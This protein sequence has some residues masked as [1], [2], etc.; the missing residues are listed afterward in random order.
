LEDD[1]RLYPAEKRLKFHAD[2]KWDYFDELLLEADILSKD[3][4]GELRVVE[5]RV[6]T[7]L[8]L[9]AFHDIMK[10]QVLL[11]TV[12][13]EHAPY[14]GYLAG[15]MICDHDHALS[16]VMDHF[17]EL[18]PSFCGLAPEEKASVQFTQCKLSFNHGWV[19]QAEAPPGAAFTKFREALMEKAEHKITQR[20][21][22]LY[23]VHWLTD[24]AGA[25]PTP[26]GGCEKFVIKFPLAVLNSF[27]RSFEFVNRI[28]DQNE[29]EVNEEYLKMRW[30]EWTPSLGPLP[31]GDGSISL[32]RLVCMAQANAKPILNGFKELSKQ[33]R[34]VLNLEMSRTGCVDQSY[35][36]AVCPQTVRD[37]PCGPAFLVYYGLVFLQ[38]LGTDPPY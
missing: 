33:D 35:S 28:A 19:V 16:Y 7:L 18:L 22:A 3:E 32:M 24:L 20:D 36:P 15:D 1:E 12:E 38:S 37:E 8:A 11:P 2:I 30:K 25:E 29:T 21:V 26:L 27:L 10:M 31:T 23:F 14:H 17:P 6:V 34:D 13:P 4:N 5:E 9:T